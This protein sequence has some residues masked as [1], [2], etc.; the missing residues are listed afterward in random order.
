M[1]RNT[2]NRFGSFTKLLHWLIFILITAQF[3]LIWYREVF[4]KDSPEKALYMMLHKSV[5]MTVL[6]LGVLFVVWH[7][8]NI[9]PTPLASQSRWQQVTAKMVHYALFALII[10]ISTVGYLLVCANGRMV[11]FFGWFNLPS[12]LTENKLLANTL[13]NIHEKLAYLILILVGIHLLAALYHHFIAK[14]QVL[15]RILPFTNMRNTP[16]R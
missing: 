2:R 6:F 14:N 10:A 3:Y 13:F 5:G 12:L 4:P 8:F 1:F 15:R 9:K 7:L 11:N 16:E